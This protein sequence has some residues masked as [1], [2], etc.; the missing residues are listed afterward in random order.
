MGKITAF[1]ALRA[2]NRRNFRPMTYRILLIM[3]GILMMFAV[4]SIVMLMGA[5]KD[6]LQANVEGIWILTG[7][8]TALTVLVV[9]IG[10]RQR[11]VMHAR[12]ETEVNAQVGTNGQIDARTFADAVG[13]TLDSA[14]EVLDTMASHRGWQRTEEAG[15]NAVY[16]VR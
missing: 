3:S 13:I 6:P 12:F 15:Y 10:L 1:G 16:R 4:F 8:C 11:S 5:Y 14:R 9:L 7:I 2:L